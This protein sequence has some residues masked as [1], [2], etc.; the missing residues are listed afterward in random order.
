MLPRRAFGGHERVV[1]TRLGQRRLG[2]YEREPAGEIGARREQILRARADAAGVAAV[3]PLNG[4]AIGLLR[5]ELVETR[6]RRVALPDRERD[7][8]R[9]HAEIQIRRCADLPRLRRHLDDV[10]ALDPQPRRG[11]WMDLDPR[12][13]QH[14]RDRIGQL[15]QPRLVRAASVAEHRREIGDEIEV[16]AR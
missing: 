10:A 13:P 3:A 5:L 14:L 16:A 15:L 8:V 2:G 11:L 9:P 1:V 4:V 7:R 12:A 6:R